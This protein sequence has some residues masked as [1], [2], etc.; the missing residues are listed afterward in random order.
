ML[1][2][3]ALDQFNGMPTVTPRQQKRYDLAM[4]GWTLVAR[5]TSIVLLGVGPGDPLDKLA[6]NLANRTLCSVFYNTAPVH[7]IATAGTLTKVQV[8][9]PPL[10]G[11]AFAGAAQTKLEATASTFLPGAQERKDPPPPS[12]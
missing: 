7:F 9:D 11:A 12:P 3:A 6:V 8:G 2:S 4:L 10:F 5:T 1:S